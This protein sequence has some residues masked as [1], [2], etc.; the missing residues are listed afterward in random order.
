HWFSRTLSV[1]L[2]S[3][4]VFTSLSLADI[5]HAASTP[6]TPFVVPRALGQITDVHAGTGRVVLIQDLHLH[7]PTQKCILGLLNYLYAKNIASGPVAVEGLNGDYDT[8]VL[9]TVP[10]GS[11]KKKLINYFM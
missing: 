9:A 7:Y 8:S 3:S 1:V 5:A 6:N 10:A 11:A 4:L 2:A